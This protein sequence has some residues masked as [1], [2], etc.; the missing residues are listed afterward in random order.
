MTPKEKAVRLVDRYLDEVINE[1]DINFP[2][3]LPKRLAI[4][5]VDELIDQCWSYREIDLGLA[6]EYWEEVKNEIEKL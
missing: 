6:L 4:I 3:E 5:A 2:L 1:T